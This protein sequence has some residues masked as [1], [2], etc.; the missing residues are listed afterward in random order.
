MTENY[1]SLDTNRQPVIGVMGSGREEHVDLAEPL[2][3][4]IADRGWHLLCGGGGGVMEAVAR[5]FASR[6][7]R[8]GVAIGVL[9]GRV[10]AGGLRTPTGYPNRWIDIPI[11]THLPFSGDQG[12]DPLSRNHINVLSVDV[13]IAL[14]GGPGTRSEVELAM[15]YQ[16]PVIAFLGDD[17]RIDGIEDGRVLVARDLEEV[18]RW[19]DET[20]DSGER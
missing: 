20:F 17:G 14:P 12:F 1:S 2:G 7:G 18:A 9:P 6:E 16:K 15:M 5:G 19:V 13:V 4:W 3:A 11:R 8:R 10:D